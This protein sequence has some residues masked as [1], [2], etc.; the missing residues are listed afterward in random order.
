MMAEPTKE[1]PTV[2]VEDEEDDVVDTKD[3]AGAAAKKKNKKKK[4]KPAAASAEQVQ[5]GVAGLDI[6]AG[7]AEAAKAG[8]ED[9]DE[10]DDEPESADGASGDA[11][12]K[13]K[14]KKKKPAAAAGTAAASA[15]GSTSGAIPADPHEIRVLGHGSFKHGQTNPPSKPVAALFPTGNFPHGEEQDYQ[16]FNLWRVT[17]A[18]KRELERLE[19]DLYESVRQAAEVHRQ[20]RQYAQGFIKPGIK[21]IDMCDKIEEMN[22]KLVQENGLK[23][24]IG[25]PT[26]CS[27]NHVAA[28]YTPNSG[29]ETV[30]QYGDVMKVDF[31]TH[32]NGRIVDCA[33]TVAFD[34]KFDPLLEAVKA[35]TN[36]GI[37]AAGIDVRLCDV[38]AEIQE[39]MESYEIELEG[40][41][42]PVKS[43]RNLNGHSIGV[44]QIHGGKS[45]PIVK[46]GDTT[47]MEEGEIF[48]IETFGST[49][50]GYVNEDMECS[51][52]AKNVDAPFVPL[53]MAKSKE[54][55]SHINKQYDTLPFCRKWLDRQG[56]TKYLAALKNLCETGIVQAYPPLVDVKGSYVAQ[57]EH[58]ILLRPT[59]KEVLSRGDDY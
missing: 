29:D 58:T 45:V 2:A 48:A 44:Y 53:R 57:Y 11:K 23:A 8:T 38:G 12:K 41:V 31:G 54:L 14:K 39:V 9:D 52:Y 22:R 49:G 47:K 59:R 32:I 51:H 42:Y 28:H 46:G 4:K 5:Q 56:Q 17:S 36:A 40:K 55:L 16:D 1:V 34:P 20:V 27:L 37:K 50:K 21:L 6:N 35:A 13:K 7:K 26:G 43:I 10:E 15:A 19:S 24:G 3:G 33:F 30:L 25:F 18:E